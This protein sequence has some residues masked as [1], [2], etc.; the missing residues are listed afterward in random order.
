MHATFLSPE[1]ATELGIRNYL[2]ADV[3]AMYSQ[4]KWPRK[5]T[6]FLFRRCV[7]AWGCGPAVAANRLSVAQDEIKAAFNAGADCV[8]LART[9][10]RK[11]VAI[12]V[13]DMRLAE[14]LAAPDDVWVDLRGL[15]QIDGVHDAF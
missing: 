15:N 12:I 4:A 5:R 14:Q 2:N 13:Q 3:L 9:V 10:D 1:Q 7:I 11:R 6:S 8:L